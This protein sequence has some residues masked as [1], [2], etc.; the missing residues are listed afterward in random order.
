MNLEETISVLQSYRGRIL[1]QVEIVESISL[2]AY[3]IFN[4]DIVTESSELEIR[5]LRDEIA[6]LE[7]DQGSKHL[8]II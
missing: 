4:L 8:G 7:A 5:Y 6:R 3:G 2:V 1:P